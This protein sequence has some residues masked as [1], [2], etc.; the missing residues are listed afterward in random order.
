MGLMKHC[1][2]EAS[3]SS[4]LIHNCLV[5]RNLSSPHAS[6]HFVAAHMGLQKCASPRQRVF[7]ANPYYSSVAVIPPPTA[8]ILGGELPCCLRLV[9]SN[10]TPNPLPFAKGEGSCPAAFGWRVQT[11]PPAPSP[12]GK[13]RGAALLPS[14]GGFKPHPQPPPLWERGGELAAETS[15]GGSNP[16]PN[17]LPFAKGEGS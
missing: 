6:R 4:T 17:P 2:S 1:L 3:A 11:P 10:P 16:T 15:A 5:L 7:D 13:G 14:A 9:G 12:L 8:L